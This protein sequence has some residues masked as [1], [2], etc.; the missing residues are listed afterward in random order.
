MQ[1][2]IEIKNLT[3]AY[4]NN[5]APTL[6][7]INYTQS[8][9]EFT[10]VMGR[11]GAG[12]TTF[13]LTLNGLIPNFKR[14]NL[15]GEIRIFGERIEGKRVSE[16][17]RKVGL[18]FQDFEAQLFST[19]VELE[20]AF[21]PENF[22]C[23]GKELSERIE[24]SLSS[25]NL[26]RFKGREPSTLSGGE[27]QRLAIASVLSIKPEILVMDEVTTDLDPKGKEEVLSVIESLRKKDITTL[28]VENEAEN[29]IGA[30]RIVV[31]DDGKVV[32]EG[33][34][35]VLQ[36]VELLE[37]YG[38]RALQIPKLFNELGED[39]R[40]IEVEEAYELLRKKNY[41]VERKKELAE[42]FSSTKVLEVK[43][44]RFVYQSGVEAL[45]GITLTVGKGEFIAIIG[46]N[47]SGKTTFAKLLSGLLQPTSG[48][49]RCFGEDIRSLSRAQVG[50]M[51]GYVFQN[52]DQ[53]LFAST[54]E[55]EVAFGP[56]NFCIPKE[57][58]SASVNEALSLMKLEH[59]RKDDPF[60]L[61]KGERQRIAIASILTLRP[62]V[63]I[64]DEPTTG[65]DYGEQKRILGFIKWLSSTESLTCLIITHSMWVV[66]EYATRVILLHDGKVSLDGSPRFVFSQERALRD[67]SIMPPSL[68]RL[69]NKFGVTM[70]SV[71]EFKSSLRKK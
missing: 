19:T 67:A 15:K 62:K 6:K 21:G 13:C 70:L 36:K 39:E 56:R 17:S 8:I 29:L 59:A 46:P 12:K 7:G 52:P 35:E 32:L 28:L 60:S 71:D 63:L 34:K 14:G 68:I 22:M 61:A 55:E 27:K 4:K 47:G 9:G 58:I 37:K 33:G 3:F 51:I 11:G 64:L 48:E 25:V 2:A 16:L 44:L 57:E 65:L 38:I 24:A 66:A 42:G 69:S 26:T 50:R 54:V 31:I 10:G 41:V 5:K 53:Q 49:V 40:P 30:D 1:K 18:V 43:D 20:V 23:D 45:R